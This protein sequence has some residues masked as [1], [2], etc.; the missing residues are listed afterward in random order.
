[1]ISP[2][3]AFL[4]TMLLVGAAAAQ[5]A[6]ELAQTG[7]RAMQQQDYATAEN[8]YRQLLQLSPEVAEVHSNLG[9]ACYSQKKLPCAEEALTQALQLAPGLFVPNFLL[10]EIRF[11]EGRYKEALGLLSKAATIQ[12]DQKEARKLFIAT[13]VGLK[14]YDRAIEE[15]DRTLAAHPDDA[16]SYYGLGS[17]YLQLGQSVIQRLANEP[18]YGA[19][20][21]AQ[22]YETSDEWRSLAL[23]AYKDAIARLPSVPAIRVG[24]AKIEIAQKN[25]EAARNALNQELRLDRESYEA[26]FQLARVVLAQGP[27]EDALQKLDEAMRIRPEFFRPLPDLAPDWTPAQRDA[28][29]TACANRQSGFATD[30]VRS[31][32]AEANG[33][34]GAAKEWAAKAEAARDEISATLKARPAG[35]STELA[36]LRLL[37]QKRYEQGLAILLPLARRTELRDETKLE[38]ARALHSTRRA[39]EMIRLF[40]GTKAMHMPEVN[41]LLG[42]SYKEVALE[43]LTHMVQVAPES[44]RAHQVLGDAYFAEQRFEDAAGE[45]EAA[46][47][48]EPGNPDL[49][50]LLGRTYFMQTQFSLALECFNRALRLDPL[51]A[52]AYLM[53]GDALVQLGETQEA[54]AP[55]SRSLELNPSLDRAHVLLGKVYSAQGKLDQALKHL[56][57]G[58]A[59]DKDGSVHYQLFVLYRKLNQPEK[60]AVALRASQELR[61]AATPAVLAGPQSP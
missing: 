53:Q 39:E 51:N 18:G 11:Q 3:R 17:V 26:R 24:Y 47:K 15:Y 38:L 22:H 57:K 56:E 36:G 2:A 5:T 60:A 9:L 12:P 1:M 10:G 13:L 40:A 33:H 48:L 41:Y 59:A 44:A 19:L 28:A 20:M 7:A 37:N 35:G 58:A 61:S 46:V 42:S 43:K 55:L 52:E 4:T 6:E 27:A 50:F 14:Q 45:Y 21:T 54:L 29:E 23:N 8:V 31:A 30:Y 34:F 25:W 32:I 16:D 49:H